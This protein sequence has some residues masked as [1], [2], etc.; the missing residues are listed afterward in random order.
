MIQAQNISVD[1]SGRRILQDVDFV[2]KPGEVTAVIG[3][4]GS[5]KTTLMKALCR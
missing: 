3:P 5:G 4:N 1:I 2:A